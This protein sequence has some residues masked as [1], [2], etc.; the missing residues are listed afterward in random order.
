MALLW[1][2][3]DVLGNGSAPRRVMTDAVG[4]FR[5]AGG[6][7]GLFRALIPPGSTWC[8]L[9]IDA[10][11]VALAA[12]PGVDVLPDDRL[13][14]VLTNQRA[15]QANNVLQRRGLPQVASAGM[16]YRQVIEAVAHELDPSFSTDWFPGVT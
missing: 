2:I 7:L 8:L 3:A 5:P 10:D 4:P 13:D 1:A 12:V 14:T 9:L 16:T 15:N 6:H 11:P